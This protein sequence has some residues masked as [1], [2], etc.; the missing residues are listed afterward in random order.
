MTTTHGIAQAS[1]ELNRRRPQVGR[2][3]RRRGAHR[4]CH[5]GAPGRCTSGRRGCRLRRVGAGAPSPT[6]LSVLAVLGTVGV[7]SLFA[8]A[9]GILRRPAAPGNP[10]IKTVVDDAF[11]GIVVTDRRPRHLRQRRLSGPD[12]GDRPADMR[13]ME[14]VFIG[15]ADVSEAIYRLLKA[16]RE[17]RRLQEE[18]RVRRRHG[19]RARW[20]RL[21]VRPLG[22]R[23]RD[24]RLTVWSLSDAGTGQ[25]AAGECLQGIAERDR[26]SRPRAGRLFLGRP[27][28]RSSISMRR[29]PSWLDLD[30]TKSAP[31]VDTVADLVAVTACAIHVRAGGAGRAEN[32]NVSISTSKRR[33]GAS[34]P[35]RLSTSLPPAR[36][37]P[38][39]RAD[40]RARPQKDDDTD[41][42]ARRADI[43]FTRFFH[44]TPMAIATVD[45]EGRIVRTNPLFA[46]LFHNALN[47]DSGSRPIGAVLAERD[48]AALDAAIAA[49]ARGKSDIAPVEAALAGDG[50]RFGS[51]YV[52]AVEEEERDQE[53]AIVYTLETTAQ[54][55]P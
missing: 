15:D 4:Q 38:R 47:L 17:G 2:S 39:R 32:R 48:R 31:A 11:D 12:R 3:Q 20:L 36:R 25:R 13:P 16:A 50:E 35:V 46:R 19:R 30:L 51:F 27:G 5:P 7:I 42:S 8:M 9:A 24:R 1:Q 23:G 44:N 18:V 40:D 33:N 26:L 45:R 43:R 21:R 6:F 28:E 53:A 29:W 37:H 22:E 54:R 49:A 41:Q 14:R 52:T 34:L 55:E 10:L